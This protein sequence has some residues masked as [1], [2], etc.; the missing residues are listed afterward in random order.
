MLVILAGGLRRK[1]V[2]APTSIECMGKFLELNFSDGR[3]EPC[4]WRFSS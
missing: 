3:F 2:E 4:S 1:V